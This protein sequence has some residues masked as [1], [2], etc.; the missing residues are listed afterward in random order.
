MLL[1]FHSCPHL[2][3]MVDHIEGEPLEYLDSNLLKESGK[4]KLESKDLKL[5]AIFVLLAL[6]VLHKEGIVRTG[7]AASYSSFHRIMI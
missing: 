7:M 4:E 5:V 6:A 2:R 3:Q 1:Q